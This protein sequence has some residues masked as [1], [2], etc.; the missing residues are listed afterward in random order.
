MESGSAV[1]YYTLFGR[2]FSWR[3]GEFDGG[4][5]G[6]KEEEPEDGSGDHGS[7]WSLAK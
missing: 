3:E 4:G 1:S 7:M 5:K 6:Q 2:D